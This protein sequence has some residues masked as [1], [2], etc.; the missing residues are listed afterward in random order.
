MWDWKYAEVSLLE[1]QIQKSTIELWV[2][3]IKINLLFD[4]QTGYSFKTETKMEAVQVRRSEKRVKEGERKMSQR[5]CKQ[6]DVISEKERD[7]SKGY[8]W[9]QIS[10]RYKRKF[11]G[12]NFWD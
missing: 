12:L 7:F 8:Q 6:N 10:K 4:R 2:K 3:A 11:W 9:S 1:T 5:A